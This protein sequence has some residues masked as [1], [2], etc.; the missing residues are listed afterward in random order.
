MQRYSQGMRGEAVTAGAGEYGD[1][2]G[3]G[4]G[5]GNGAAPASHFTLDTVVINSVEYATVEQVRQMGATAT[6]NGA[7]AG[8]ARALGRL[9]TSVGARRKLGMS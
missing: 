4:T 5:E 9:R 2:S 6:A 1:G 7:R 3:G 8:E